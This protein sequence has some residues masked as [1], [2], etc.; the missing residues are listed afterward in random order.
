MLKIQGRNFLSSYRGVTRD[1]FSR[2][3]TSMVD[4]CE[5]G[6]ESLRLWEV[7][8][9]VHGHHLEG[10]RMGVGRDWLQWGFSV[11]R[12]WFILLAGGALLR[13]LPSYAYGTMCDSYLGLSD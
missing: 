10:S 4:Y 8:Y 9:Q 2:F 6:I 1:E 3:R 11:S 7:R 12:T 13:F 5:D